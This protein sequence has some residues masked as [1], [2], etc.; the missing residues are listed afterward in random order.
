[1]F[2]SY[3]PSISYGLSTPL[4]QSYAVQAEL[5]VRDTRIELVPTAWEAVVLPL[6]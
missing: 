6:N 4:R 3:A 2:L 5:F 1:M